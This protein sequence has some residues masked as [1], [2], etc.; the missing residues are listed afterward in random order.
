MRELTGAWKVIAAILVGCW[1][2][3][4]VY[5]A[6][7]IALHPLLQGGVSLSF[8]LALVFLL[9]PLNQKR[10]S[11]KASSPKEKILYG[12][13]HSPSWLDVFLSVIAVIPCTYIMIYWEDV[14][15]AV[16][17]YENYQLILGVALI[18]VLLEGTRRALGKAIPVLVLLFLLY[19]LVGNYIPGF[20]GH[21]GYHYTEILYQLYLMTEGIW[22]LLTDL[23]SRVIALF[24]IFGPVLFAVGVGKGFMDLARFTGGRMTGGAG[25]IA[26]I[27]SAFFG[28]LSGS[29]VANVAT[30][31]SFTIPT[32]KKVGYKSELAG[33]IEAS[34]SSGGQITPPIMGAGAFVM[35]EF[36]NIPYLTVMLAAVIPAL[37]YYAG[38]WAGIYVEAKR[39][40]LGKLPP[41]LIPKLSEVF[42][43]RQ[44]VMVFIPI[45]LLLI[46]LLM[47]LPPQLCAAWSLIGAM[48]LF[49]IVG[50]SLNPKAAWERI[51][52]IAE[53]YYRGVSAALA[54][55]MVMM[56]CVQMAVTMISLTGFGVKI[57]E[58]IMSLA[59]INIMLALIATMIC[60][61]ILGMGMTTT[62]A[63]VIAAAVL[64][65]ALEGL[66]LP[67]LAGHL[68]I[69]WYA[70]KSGLTPPVCIACFTA[71]AI[72]GASWIRLAWIAIRLGIG[73]YLMPFFFVFYPV[74]LMRGTPFEVIMMAALAILAMFPLEAA[75]MGHFIKPTTV[76]ER[77]IFFA[78]GLAVLHPSW[79][80]DLIG[81]A[82]IGLGL[83]S[84]KFMVL[85]IPLIGR[86]PASLLEINS[87]GS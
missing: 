31:G 15:R 49:M 45:G 46:L 21:A 8:G 32:M 52:I 3:F 42:A 29:A 1:S 7:T 64:G 26:V 68:F 86:R 34:A 54:W 17:R 67:P 56:S 53:A 28:M 66:G 2:I 76:L 71:A 22:G 13:L 55:L 48:V 6:L 84:Q 63:Y 85:P 18:I 36:L 39:Y 83:L 10:L 59:G 58:I 35:A 43:P 80:T 5:T 27:S 11:A 4:L 23:T 75:V 72:A 16:G 20:F 87:K 50:G 33:A 70:I 37:V 78:G 65:P 47:Y 9:Y 82:L 74:F 25:Q 51:K 62:A 61:I 73:G 30:T 38:V 81:L 40:G 12:T 24:V 69:F 14:A 44:V 41:E 57:S 19:A 60:A 79:T 77:L